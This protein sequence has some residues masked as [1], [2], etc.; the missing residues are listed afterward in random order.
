MI[1]RD[2]LTAL[3]A[4]VVERM[5]PGTSWHT[6]QHGRVH[7][8]AIVDEDQIVYRTWQKH[9]RRWSYR[10]EWAYGFWLHDR[11]GALSYKGKFALDN[12]PR[13]VVE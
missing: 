2:G 10:V 9:K 8:L 13:S 12:D 3:L 5:Q 7:V 1:T 4:A 6:P 11:E